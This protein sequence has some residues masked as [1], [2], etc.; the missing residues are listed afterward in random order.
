[1][2][3]ILLEK[4]KSLL[5]ELKTNIENIDVNSSNEYSF[6][7]KIIGKWVDGTNVYRKCFRFT[8]NL[9]YYPTTWTN[10][11]FNLICERII[12]ANISRNDVYD[13]I[14]CGYDSDG[15]LQIK[16]PTY[17]TTVSTGSILI[18][19]YTKNENP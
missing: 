11:E 15:T 5:S 16:A 6:D 13:M 7:E 10:T 9:I 1:M 18:V 8:S 17:E 3:T 12:F 19:D 14:F 2:I 4:I